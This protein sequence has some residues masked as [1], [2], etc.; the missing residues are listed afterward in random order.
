VGLPLADVIW[1][2]HIS[3]HNYPI[4]EIT[5]NDEAECGRFSFTPGSA[6]ASRKA[7]FGF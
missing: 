2:G 7:R 4:T 1:H 3:I 5:A 6:S